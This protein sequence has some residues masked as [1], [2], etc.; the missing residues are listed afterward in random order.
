LIFSCFLEY[1]CFLAV[2]VPPVSRSSHW[3]AKVI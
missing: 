2:S 1:A 3:A